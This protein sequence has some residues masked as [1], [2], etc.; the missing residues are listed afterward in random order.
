MQ[1]PYIDQIWGVLKKTQ[2]WQIQTFT[3]RT[4]METSYQNKGHILIKFESTVSGTISYIIDS[5]YKCMHSFI[6]FF[7]YS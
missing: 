2:L 7:I 5:S 3:F 6:K 4:S 1:M